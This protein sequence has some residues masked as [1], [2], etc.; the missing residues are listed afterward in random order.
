MFLGVVPLSAVADLYSAALAGLA[1]L[2]DLPLF[3]GARPAKVMPCLA[4]GTP[5]V[6]SGSG[7]GARL[8][9]EADAGIVVD[10]EDGAAIAGA[11]ERL[12]DDPGLVRAARRERAP[13]RRGAL[14]LAGARRRL[15]RAAGRRAAPRPPAP[16]RALRVGL[17][18][19]R[20]RVSAAPAFM[21][22]IM[23]ST[24]RRAWAISDEPRRGVIRT[25]DEDVEVGAHDGCRALARNATGGV[26]QRPVVAAH[27]LP[28]DRRERRPAVRVGLADGQQVE[29]GE[30]RPRDGLLE[31]A[32]APRR[33]RLRSEQ[34]VGAM[35]VVV[36]VDQQDAATARGERRCKV[37]GD[38]GLALAGLRAR[39]L[40]QLD[41]WREVAHGAR[42]LRQRPPT[43]AA[44]V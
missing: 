27:E 43:A 23:G 38:G 3:E 33:A 29:I 35:P 41:G 37:R 44:P 22:T 24:L 11:V 16:A 26:E 30:G 19:W 36:G 1:T 42:E 20:R 18:A 7:E 39:D 31:R 32:G 15:A 28:G 25:G 6:Y 9:S 8:V 34:E 17:S 40:N 13:T 21:T 5:L 10:P 14:Q 4:S 12:L 2:R